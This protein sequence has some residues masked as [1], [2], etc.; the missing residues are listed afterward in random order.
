MRPDNRYNKGKTLGDLLRAKLVLV[1]VCRRCKH[2]H[3]LYPALLIERFGERTH[4]IDIR[5]CLRCRHCR[6]R[7]ANLHEASR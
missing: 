3:I 5:P 1:A 4:A 7:N 2:E 6:Y